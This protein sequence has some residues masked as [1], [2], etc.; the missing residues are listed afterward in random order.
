MLLTSSRPANIRS[1]PLI[2]GK[3]PAP[4]LVTIHLPLT[5]GILMRHLLLCAVFM[6]GTA[7]VPGPKVVERAVDAYVKPLVGRGDLAGQLLILRNGQVL[8]ERGLG[9]ANRELGAPVTSETR[10]N[11]A[12]VTKPMTGTVAIQLI[13]EKKLGLD[14]PLSKW[15]PDFPKG[16][17]ITVAHLLRHRSGIPHEIMS[18]SVMTHPFTAAD[19]VALAKRRQL[20]FSPGSRESYSSG[21][22]EVLAR[23]LELAGGTSYPKLM[24]ERI[25]GP[26][27]MT[28]SSSP[29]SQELLP[30]RAAS[31]I[32]GPNGMENAPFQ[33][34]SGLMGAG[35]VWS[36]ARDLHLFVQAVVTGKLGESPRQSYVRNG[37]LEFN[38][39]TGGFKAW[40]VWDSTGTE[41]IFTGNVSTGAPDALKND[42]LRLAAGESVSP[43]SLPKLRKDPLPLAELKTWEGEYQIEHGPHISLQVKQGALYASDWIMLPAEDGSMFCPRDYG[44][45]RRVDGPDGTPIRLDWI[46]GSETY[47]APRVSGP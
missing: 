26:L 18:D 1:W 24:Q 29:N 2:A 4:G 5:G 3:T 44:R 45:V 12:S 30:E 19:I 7:A 47:P 37:Q 22:F 10:F 11:I 25:F 39:R 43:P 34:F 16:D 13:Q 36:T 40:A 46:E 8:V 6:L 28:H 9:L 41:A 15:I 33:D 14:D 38:G 42:V 35:S 31:Y 32:P 27:K 21:G 17:S 23:V 20:D